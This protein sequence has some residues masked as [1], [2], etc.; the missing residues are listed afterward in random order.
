M[1]G[2]GGRTYLK[3]YIYLIEHGKVHAI[4]KKNLKNFK[5]ETWAGGLSWDVF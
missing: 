5:N 2:P 3:I 4:V 1:Y